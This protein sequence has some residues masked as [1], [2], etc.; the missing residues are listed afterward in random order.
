MIILRNPSF[1]EK[2]ISNYREGIR[3][4]FASKIIQSGDGGGAGDTGKVR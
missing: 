2:Y 3:P 1:R 4:G